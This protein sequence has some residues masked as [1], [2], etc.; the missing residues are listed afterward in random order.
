MK[1]SKVTPSFLRMSHNIQPVGKYNDYL[2]IPRPFFSIAYIE[3]GYGEFVSEG[4]GFEACAGDMLFVPKGSTYISYWKGEPKTQ[5]LSCHFDFPMGGPLS[6]KRF[7]VQKLSGSEEMHEAMLFLWEHLK[8]P[9]DLFGVL[10]RFFLVLEHTEKELRFEPIPE[11]DRRLRV[12]AEYIHTHFDKELKVE[13]IAAQCHMSLPYFYSCFRKVYGVSP[14][15]YKNRV[16][17]QRAEQLLEEDHNLPVEE[18]SE[19]TGFS[20]SSYFRRVFHSVTGMSPREYRK[21]A[22]G[23]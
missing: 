12:A 2:K 6:E 14:I 20:S 3:E 5:F 17:V 11:S 22:K 13:S 19:M 8:N 23:L 16:A 1:L 7:F 15:E 18:I 21:R 4:K 9:D 10:A